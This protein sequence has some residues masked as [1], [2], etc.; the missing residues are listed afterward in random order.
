V[1]AMVSGLAGGTFFENYFN[2]ET[3]TITTRPSPCPRGQ[4]VFLTVRNCFPLTQGE[5]RQCVGRKLAPTL[6]GEGCVI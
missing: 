1:P 5:H 6:K 2:T 4:K 3:S